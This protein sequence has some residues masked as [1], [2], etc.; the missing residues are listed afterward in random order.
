MFKRRGRIFAGILAVMLAF[1]SGGIS[2]LADEPGQAEEQSA[3]TPEENEQTEEVKETEDIKETEEI[4]EVEETE[5]IEE[6]TTRTETDEEDNLQETDNV[7]DLVV[8]ETE[9][10]ET[11]DTETEE[12]ETDSI[13]TYDASPGNLENAKVQGE[14]PQGT[15]IN[16]F[17][18]WQNTQDASDVED[19]QRPET[20]TT[21]I[22]KDAA[23]KFGKGMSTNDDLSPQFLNAWTGSKAVR[24]E[25]VERVLTEDGYPQLTS[26][27]SSSET[28]KDLSYL[29]SPSV[30]HEGKASYPG[31]EGL[32]QMDEDGYYYYDSMQTFAE[33]DKDTRK[34]NL[35]EGSYMS[36]DGQQV[37]GAVF[38]AGSSPDGQ[39]FPFN[40]A[41]AVYKDNGEGGVTLDDLENSKITS[42]HSSINHYFGMTMS[43]RFFQQNEGKT[44]DGTSVTYEFA[45][46]DDVWVFIDDVLVADLG[47]IHDRATLEID[48][49][50]GEIVINKRTAHQ[51]EST[52][53]EQFELAKKAGDNSGWRGNTFADGT[54]HTLSF[55]YL[56][57]GNT[58][59]NLYLK[60]NLV[61]ILESGV[62]K[63]DQA[64]KKIPGAEFALYEATKQGEG[65]YTYDDTADPICSGTTGAAGE[66]IFRDPEDGRPISLS[67]IYDDGNVKN[68]ILKET[69]VPDGYRSAGDMQLRFEQTQNGEVFLL[70]DN[71]WYTGAYATAKVTATTDSATIKLL[72]EEKREINLDEEG[73]TLFAVVMQRQDMTKD[74]KDENNWRPVYGD[75]LDGW[76]VVQAKD[77][78]V[79]G[80]VLEAARANPYIFKHPLK[81]S[82]LYSADI[83]NLPGDITKYYY[84]LKESERDKE[85]KYTVGYYY[86]KAATLADAKTDNT[87]RVD[88]E[89]FGRNFSANLYVPNVQN[90]LFVQKLDEDGVP[91][92]AGADQSRSAEF[93][94]YPQN[95][96]KIW[97]DGT[98]SVTGKNG[99]LTANTSDME[100]P[101]PLTGGAMFQGVPNGDYYLIETKAPEGYEK[102]KNIVQVIVDNTGVY[103]NAGTAKDDITVQRGVGSIVHSMIQFAAEDDVDLTLHDIKTELYTA[104]GTDPPDYSSTSWKKDEDKGEIH[105]QFKEGMDTLNYRTQASDGEDYGYYTID[106]G[107]SKLKV[108]QCMDS[109]HAPKDRKQDLGE[110]DLTHLFSRTVIVQVKN[111]SIGQLTIHKKVV[112]NTGVSVPVPGDGF[113]FTLTGTKEDNSALGGKLNAVRTSGGSKLA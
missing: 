1:S 38:A 31:A 42:T 90:N 79:M 32:L 20:L 10:T 101:L 91:V 39:F 56:E 111:K 49:S 82:P 97:D 9:N 109:T 55:F 12:A 59:S 69:K 78:G 70:S 41:K 105:L 113:R 85:A 86:T 73:G 58:D 63:V 2:A 103:A 96:V 67:D 16:L 35:Y 46:D 11:E 74:V 4:K 14:A 89:K 50:T 61:T 29:F 80:A 64:G 75:P 23:L 3:Q 52:L 65:S 21:G 84:V 18:Y 100:K 77:G 110:Q 112:N 47:G 7:R 93:T 94:L 19:G 15:T 92:S 30:D 54:Y 26:K 8:S 44:T 66:L 53:K 25:I 88:S 36:D 43:T 60:F 99:N 57:R 37:G 40:K 48:F 28:E 108:L 83:E 106:A 95:N 22:N 107:W 62:I 87:Y 72:N 102:S 33:Y 104:D 5:E 71:H 27:A 13:E 98:Y 6:T 17:D 34:F 68:L 51:I 24:R 76:H 81:G 45:G